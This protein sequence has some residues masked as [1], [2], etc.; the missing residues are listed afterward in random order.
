M[1]LIGRTSTLPPALQWISWLIPLRHY[2][3]IVRGVMVRGAGIGSL[4]PEVGSILG[5]TVVMLYV[6]QRTLSRVIE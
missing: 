3:G 6:A 2:L 5:L 4:L 1:T